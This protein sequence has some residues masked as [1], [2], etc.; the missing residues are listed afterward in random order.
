MTVRNQPTLRLLALL[1]AL[2]LTT[3]ACIDELGEF[4]EFLAF[5]ESDDPKLHQ[6]GRWYRSAQDR[7]EEDRLKE[8]FLETGDI[9]A[10]EGALEANP[11]DPEANAMLV[12]HT[13]LSGDAEAI[14]DV[15]RRQALTV[16]RI[17]AG[18]GRS[19]QFLRNESNKRLLDAQVR[20]LGHSSVIGWN[21]TPPG[22]EAPA[23]TH[24]VFE[25]YCETRQLL[26]DN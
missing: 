18:Q 7:D 16:A 25:D 21:F 23:R 26:R 9:G 12:V 20:M 11:N 6:R 24:E 8:R 4:L 2:T 1:A 13:R 19:P 5:I 15:E 14:E 17:Y 3:T 22:P 10:L